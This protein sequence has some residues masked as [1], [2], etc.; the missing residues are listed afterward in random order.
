M[1]QD[2][3]D[4][5]LVRRQGAYPC[6]LHTDTLGCAWTGGEVWHDFPPFSTPAGPLGRA[7]RLISFLWA[8]D[9]R[10]TDP[11]STKSWPR[12]GPINVQAIGQKKRCSGHGDHSPVFDSSPVR[13]QSIDFPECA[14][15]WS[16]ASKLGAISPRSY[17]E[18]W[19]C[20]TPKM[21]PN[22][23]CV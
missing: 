2:H 21:R 10:G 15:S 3:M 14:R 7:C 22:S 4:P 1:G 19:V 11:H 5:E 20:A 18:S 13:I 9:A 6:D 8:T 16:K 23:S 12:W 17:L